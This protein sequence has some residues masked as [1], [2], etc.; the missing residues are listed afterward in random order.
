MRFIIEKINE[1]DCKIIDCD[2]SDLQGKSI[3]EL[4]IPSFI[5]EEGKTYKV[6]EVGERAC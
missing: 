3:K 4:V 5:E 1:T 2:C 6:K